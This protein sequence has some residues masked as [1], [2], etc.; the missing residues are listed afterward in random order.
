MADGITITVPRI[1]AATIAP[2]PAIINGT[3]T[4]SIRVSEESIV[5]DPVFFYAGEIHSGEV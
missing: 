2:N 5:L 3:F 1:D 4:L